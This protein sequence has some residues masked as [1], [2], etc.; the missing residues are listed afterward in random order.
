MGCFYCVCDW[1]E[2]SL[3]VRPRGEG[4]H[5][6]V[7]VKPIYILILFTTLIQVLHVFVSTNNKTW[8][9][10]DPN[11]SRKCDFTLRL[12]RCTRVCLFSFI[13]SW[14]QKEH[15]DISTETPV[16]NHSWHIYVF[17]QS[18]ASRNPIIL[19]GIPELRSAKGVFMNCADL[20]KSL[21]L[22]DV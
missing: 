3:S 20:T 5:L 12:D 21:I 16:T 14:F 2:S 22:F 6:W 18:A 11:K 9:P 19:D 8:S 4:D 13:W 10:G 15:G 1:W 7:E 17:R